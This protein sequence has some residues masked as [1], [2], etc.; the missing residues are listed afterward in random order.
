MMKSAPLPDAGIVTGVAF[1]GP[2]VVFTTGF[3][4]GAV[5]LAR[6]RPLDEHG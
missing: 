1:G 5:D 2:G 6:R 4:N 3:F